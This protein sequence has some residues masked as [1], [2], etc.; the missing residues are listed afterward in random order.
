MKKILLPH[1]E[2]YQKDVLNFLV[3][4]NKDRTIV[5]NSPR[6]CGKS[7]LLEILLIYVSMQQGYSTSISISPIN[8]QSRK[9]FKDVCSIAYKLIKT[10]NSQ[11]LEVTFIN[12]S[13][14]KFFSAESGDNLRGH[15]AN[16][17]GIVVVD[18]AAYIKDDFYWNIVVPYV[19]VSHNDIVVASTPKYTQGLFYN[20]YQ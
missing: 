14:I 8:A 16:G 12:G 17:A 6:Q 19:N 2:Q 18:E 11:T 9:M 15:N 7:S 5:I 13:V 10:S 3:Q 1:L 4:N 20:L